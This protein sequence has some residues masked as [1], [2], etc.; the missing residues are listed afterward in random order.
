ML[1]ATAMSTASRPTAR[2]TRL[3]GGVMGLSAMLGAVGFGGCGT[4]RGH[5][6]TEQLILSDAVDRSVSTIDFRPLA[7]RSV[8]LDTSYLRNVKSAGFVNADYVTSALRQQ[9]AASGCRLEDKEADAELII[10]ARMGTLGADD[11]RVTFGVP[12]N[13]ALNSTVSLIPN[14]P[15]VPQIPEIAVARR[16]A[17]EAAAKIAAFAYDRETRQAVWQSGISQSASTARDTWIM[18]VGPFQGG[19]IRDDTRL[20]GSK[21]IRF[22]KRVTRPS[23]PTRNRPPV[24]YTA[25]M[26]FRDGYPVQDASGPATGLLEGDLDLANESAAEIAGNSAA[27]Q[28][29]R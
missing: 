23:G 3:L 28:L 15:S 4:T 24:D 2:R 26:E 7:G 17:R 11:H 20:A 29:R 27:E 16:D 12:E 13:N 25:E 10:E 1:S 9:I 8:Y 18:G 5:H 19:S 22:G 6:A 21:L 14:A